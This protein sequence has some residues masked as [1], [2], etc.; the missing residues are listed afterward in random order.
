MTRKTAYIASISAFILFAASVTMLMRHSGDPLTSGKS[1]ASALEAPLP[2]ND[3]LL[4]A[5]QDAKL[6]IDGLQVRSAEGIVI[7][8]GR[9][10]DESAR[11]Q[12]TNV[13]RQIGVNRVANMI[14]IDAQLPDDEIARTAER[15]LVAS[16]DLNGCRFAVRCERGILRVSGS[17]VA[18]HQRDL[19]ARAVQNINGVREVHTDL[20]KM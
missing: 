5:L 16:P 4:T 11:E 19:A 12:A 17:I 1:R 2:G 7:V 6:P 20:K 18:D 9:T 15:R 8:R 3:T 10:T 13:L 14:K